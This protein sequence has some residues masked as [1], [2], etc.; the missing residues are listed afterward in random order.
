MPLAQER[1]IGRARASPR[2]DWQATRKMAGAPP[3]YLGTIHWSGRAV[4]CFLEAAFGQSPPNPGTRTSIV[5]F[6]ALSTRFRAA[7]FG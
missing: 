1:L 3:W 6:V 4:P 5:I 2:S 7:T